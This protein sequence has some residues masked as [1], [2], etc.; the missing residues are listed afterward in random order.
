MALELAAQPVAPDPSVLNVEQEAQT[1][2]TAEGTH[3]PS[4][5]GRGRC[6]GARRCGGCGQLRNAFGFRLMLASHTRST[7]ASGVFALIVRGGKPNP[8]W[9]A[10]QRVPTPS[11][12]CP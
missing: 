7:S 10:V 2:V 3:Q 4:L 6:R 11:A 12:N 8:R 9:V 1:R 5:R